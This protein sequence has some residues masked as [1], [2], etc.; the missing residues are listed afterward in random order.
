MGVGIIRVVVKLSQP[1]KNTAQNSGYSK[2][3]SGF[4]GISALHISKEVFM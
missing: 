4:G 1:A 3:N 2:P